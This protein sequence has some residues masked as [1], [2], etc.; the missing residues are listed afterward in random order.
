MT[1]AA[2]RG[3]P[4]FRRKFGRGIATRIAVAALASAALGLAI[5]AVGVTVVGGEVFR[6][7][8]IEAGSS[9]EHAQ[10]MYDD[11]VTRVVVGAV[12]VATIASVVLA[13]ILARML[14][15]PLAEV[16]RAARRME[17]SRSFVRI[18]RRGCDWHFF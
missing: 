13:V 17:I 16:G 9:A 4:G 2:S 15:R 12:V 10:E 1:D 8:M 3:Q 6:A 18:S 14:A 7:L 5:L 11:S